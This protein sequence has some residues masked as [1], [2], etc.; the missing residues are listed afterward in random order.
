MNE[1]VK[2]LCDDIIDNAIMPVLEKIALDYGYKEAEKAK[3][4]IANL[5][6]CLYLEEKRG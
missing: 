5:T 6:L 3:K 1:K 4:Y 2:E